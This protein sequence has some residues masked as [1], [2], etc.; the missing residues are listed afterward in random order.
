MDRFLTRALSFTSIAIFALISARLVSQDRRYALVIVGV[1]L[2]F[3]IPALLSRR[4]MRRLLISGDLPRI[5]GTWE[6][7]LERVTH[8]ETMAPLMTATA[9]AAYGFIDAARNSLSRA[10]RGPAWDA[11]VEQRLFVEAL[12][13]VYEGERSRA[14]TKATELEHLPLPPAGFW[15]RRKIALLRR[16]IGAL[17][18][19]FA[20]ESRVEDEA[21]LSRAAKSSPLVHWAMRYAKAVML[22]DAGRNEEAH[23]LIASA[24]SWPEESAFHAFHA[25]LVAH[26]K[27]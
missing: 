22:V 2:A 10:A 25:E 4:R 24:P 6:R 1:M 13:D 16:G 11:A 20:H 14:M 27:T 23:D 8:R 9:Y 18:R 3:G 17:A 19:A 26:S 21:V 12:L 7:S 15:M 5:L